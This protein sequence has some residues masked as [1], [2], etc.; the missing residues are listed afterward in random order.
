MAG[1][2]RCFEDFM[3][4]LRSDCESF[5]YHVGE[6]GELYGDTYRRDATFIMQRLEDFASSNGDA[7]PDIL[8]LYEGHTRELLEEY[9]AYRKAGRYPHSSEG[10]IEH[11]VGGEQFKKEYLYI[12]TLST[13]LNR[14]RYEVHLHFKEMAEKYLRP[15]SAILEIGGGNCLDALVASD[16]GKVRVYEKNELSRAWCGLLGLQDKVELKTQTYRFDEPGRYDFVVMIELLE[17]VT[18]PSAYLEGAYAVL[19]EG[20]LAYLTFALRMPQVDHLY[21]FTTVEECQAMIDAAGLRVVEE[22]CTIS[23]HRPFEEKER[24]ELARDPQYPATY[25]CLVGKPAPEEVAPQIDS[26]NEEL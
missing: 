7:L 12:L 14:S 25:C 19:A 15:G 24:W 1:T 20:G 13:A 26:F 22:Y 23:S 3:S 5:V 2:I 16:Y 6:L 9:K 17:H 18:D 4:R 10:E 21:E 11:L 8:R